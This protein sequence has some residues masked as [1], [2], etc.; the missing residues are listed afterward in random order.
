MIHSKMMESLPSAIGFDNVFALGESYM[1]ISYV[2]PT[3]AD[4]ELA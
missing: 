2:V 1:F 4:V 3:D